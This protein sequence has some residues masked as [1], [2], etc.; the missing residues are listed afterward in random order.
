MEKDCVF[1]QGTLT[2]GCT[3]GKNQIKKDRKNEKKKERPGLR[4]LSFSKNKHEMN[5][6]PSCKVKSH[7]T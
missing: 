7:N 4:H 5:H 3:Y 2:I 6:E 1:N